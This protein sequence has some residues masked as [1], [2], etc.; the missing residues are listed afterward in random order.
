M[1]KFHDDPEHSARVR[2]MERYDL[3]VVSGL[4]QR[5]ARQHG[6]QPAIDP[7]MLETDLFCAT[8]WLH[9]LVVERF[10]Y[11][12]GYALMTPRY[13]AQFTQRGLD[14]HHL[15]LLEGSRGLGLGRRL[16]DGVIAFARDAD[17]RFVLVG[18]QGSNICAQRF[19]EAVGFLPRAGGDFTMALPISGNNQPVRMPA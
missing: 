6:D 2:A 3:A 15:Y 4:I 16:V 17:C 1:S 8:P 18:A 7:A 5:L 9:G 14:L 10:S 19:Y 13:H 11:V 12:V